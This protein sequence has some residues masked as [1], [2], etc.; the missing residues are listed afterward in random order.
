[1]MGGKINVQST[2]GKGSIFVAQIPQR[3]SRMNEGAKFETIVINRAHRNEE[4]KQI[5]APMLSKNKE[6][7]E[8]YGNKKIL[9]VD[10]NAL[11]IKV[12]KRALADFDLILED[13]TSGQKC[14]DLIKG[15]AKYD[16][17]L[18]DIM[19]PG[20]SGEQCLLELKK[21]PNF[22][23]PVIA[24]T[25]DAVQGAKEK[26]MKSGFNDYIAKPFSRNQ[27]KDKLDNFI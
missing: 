18:M 11:N 21:D 19:M 2:Y 17:I 10:D 14:I 7:K 6:V 15:G 8:T 23:T 13:C 9:I 27:I 4:A 25:A 20:I 26:Y 16:L 3:I 5:L 12:A 24:L 1:M 22:K